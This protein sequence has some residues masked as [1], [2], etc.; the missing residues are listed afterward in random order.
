MRPLAADLGEERSVHMLAV[1]AAKSV[2]DSDVCDE[3]LRFKEDCQIWEA[4]DSEHVITYCVVSKEVK[5]L[6]EEARVM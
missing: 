2:A 6:D 5:N 3:L 1:A 4:K